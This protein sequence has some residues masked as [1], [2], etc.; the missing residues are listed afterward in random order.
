MSSPNRRQISHRSFSS[1]IV[2]LFFSIFSLDILVPNLI[3]AKTQASETGHSTYPW[4]KNLRK[5]GS[6][7][8]LSGRFWNSL[9]SYDDEGKEVVKADGES[10][11]LGEAG[12]RASYGITPEFQASLLG[13]F[14]YNRAVIADPAATGETLTLTKSGINDVGFQLQYAFERVENMHYA[15][16]LFYLY[17]PFTNSEGNVSRPEEN[18]IL[19]DDGP[20][21]GFG[22]LASAYWG[23]RGLINIRGGYQRPGRELSPELYGRVEFTL[24]YPTVAW[25]VGGEGLFSLKQDAYTTDPQNKSY[26]NTG[27]SKLFHSVNRTYLAP[28]VGVNVRL[29]RSWRAEVR[30]QQ[31]VKVASYDTGTQ[32]TFDLV[33]RKEPD[34]QGLIDSSFKEYQLEANVTKVSSQKQYVVIDKGLADNLRTGQLFDL[35]QFDFLGGNVLVARAQATKVKVN[36]SVLKIIQRLSLRHDIKEGLIARALVD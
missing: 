8:R 23:Q 22:L 27:N 32:V 3:E 25:I 20:G 29:G 18:F 28:L 19:G 26:R 10:F 33:Y 6:E 11:M 21:Y 5:R 9:N 24:A 35:F 12:L 1:T 30:A 7:Y 31:I 14:R 36:Q 34:L 15:L 16:E 17:R 2:F 13:N 4:A